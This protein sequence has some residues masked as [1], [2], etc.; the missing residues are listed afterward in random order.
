MH[1]RNSYEDITNQKKNVMTPYYDPIVATSSPTLTPFGGYEPPLPPPSQ[2][3]YLPEIRTELKVCE[4]NTANSSVDEPTEVE[5]KELPPHL[6]VIIIGGPT[7]SCPSLLLKSWMLRRK[8]PLLRKVLKSHKRLSPWKLSSDIQKYGVTHRLSTGIHPQTI[9]KWKYPNPYKTPMRVYTLQALVYGT[10]MPSS[11]SEALAQ[12][13]TGPLKAIKLRSSNYGDHRKEF[14]SMKLMKW[15]SSKRQKISKN[16][17]TE[18]GMEKTVQNQGQSPKMPKSSQ[19]LMN[20]QSNR[21]RNMK[22]TIGRN[23]NPTDGA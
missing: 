14:N 20:Q 1:K 18:H 19:Y 7:A 23:L 13:L 11:R 6:E 2:G 17:K 15:I 4:T 21:S 3:T 8:I 22:N 9:V 5:L 12:S 16:D 10:G